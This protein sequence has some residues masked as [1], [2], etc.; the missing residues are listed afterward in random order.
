MNVTDQLG[1]AL[2]FDR[3]PQRIVSLVP[4]ITEWL[5]DMGL[6]DRVVG[7]TKFCVRP[8]TWYRNKPRIGGT[9]QVHLDRL[10]PLKPDL[11][12]ANKEENDASD[13]AAIRAAGI[14]VWTSDVRTWD[15]ALDMMHLLGELLEVA[16]KASALNTELEQSAP[17][18]ITLSK[19]AAYAVWNAP[20]MLAGTDTFIHDILARLGF[21]NVV[22]TTRYPAFTD[23]ELQAAQPEVLL[24]PSEP[25]PFAEKHLPALQARFPNIQLL[26]VDGEI[27]SWYGSRMKYVKEY[28]GRLL[29]E[30]KVKSEE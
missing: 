9:K 4:S 10:L 6:E 1:I 30:L 22:Q 27:F 13:V 19:R 12:I 21:E 16:D 28:G 11:V 26:L 15:D 2:E 7:I 3:S 20:L 14:P 23:P 8:D 18:P 25:F 17:N 29:G 24:L 5:W